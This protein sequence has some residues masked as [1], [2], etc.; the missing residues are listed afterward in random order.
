MKKRN[1]VIIGISTGGPKTLKAFFDG[2][3]LLDGSI[4]L[5]QHMIK[6]ANTS[7]TATL[8]GLT[9]LMWEASEIGAFPPMM[10]F[11]DDIFN[12]ANTIFSP[13]TLITISRPA[14]PGQPPIMK[15]PF[16]PNLQLAQ[17]DFNDMR[18]WILKAFFADPLGPV[19]SPKKTATEVSIRQQAFLEEI[20]TAFGRLQVEFLSRIIERCTFILKKKGLIS[21]I[22]LDGKNVALRY[23]SPLARL[24]QQE[25]LQNFS[26]ATQVVQG[27]MGDLSIAAFDLSKVPAWVAEKTNSNLEL[28][29]T[30]TELKALQKEVQDKLLGQDQDQQQPPAQVPTAPL[31]SQKG[32]LPTQQEG[33][34]V[35]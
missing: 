6:C 14:I 12:P 32:I 1:I 35:S 9:E 22:K 27:L 17:L 31:G 16:E 26:L 21:N 10:A 34:S 23:E 15:L 2:M 25:D 28:F 29:R 19:D 8:N 7:L 13:K 3:P 33:Q 18:S 30:P 4:V 11:S 20:G 5:V 24:Q